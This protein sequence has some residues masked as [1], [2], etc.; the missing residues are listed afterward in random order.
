M[1]D[2]DIVPRVVRGKFRKVA[3]LAIGDHPA[4]D[5][6]EV[7]KTAVAA[8]LRASGLPPAGALVGALRECAVFG[9]RDV[10]EAEARR[11]RDTSG[12]SNVALEVVAE[13]ERL[14]ETRRDALRAMGLGETM[15]ALLGGGIRRAAFAA[16]FGA[17]SVTRTMLA[18]SNRSVAE[19]R[20]YQRAIVDHA[21]TDAMARALADGPSNR[22][23]APRAKVRATTAEMLDE[24]LG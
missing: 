21:Q 11:F 13:G 17:E 24:D 14:L 16:T 8:D 22:V 12:K 6:G 10:W 5:V 1:P 7:L 15:E 18:E 23:R 3:R 2:N 4:P 9:D 19:I 20:S